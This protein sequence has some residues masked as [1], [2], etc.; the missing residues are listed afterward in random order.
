MNFLDVLLKL[1]PFTFKD[2]SGTHIGIADAG[3]G[4]ITV[5][6]LSLWLIFGWAFRNLLQSKRAD[7]VMVSLLHDELLKHKGSMEDGYNDF[8]E[9]L[10]NVV[11]RF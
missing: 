8:V 5:F 1:L 9:S 3:D 6:I 11:T 7:D 4:I 10:N 2:D